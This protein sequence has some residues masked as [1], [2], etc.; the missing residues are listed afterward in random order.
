[1]E[2]IIHH[3]EGS[4]LNIMTLIMESSDN[5]EPHYNKDRDEVILVLEGNLR[6]LFDCNKSINI[7]S[8]DKKPWHLIKSNTTH[9]II[10]LSDKVKILEII[11]GVHKPD[12][13]IMAK[14]KD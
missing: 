10:P 1:M 13:C 2:R 9:Q 3:D 7:S 8:V 14:F 5:S 6:I 12:S 4:I 11:G